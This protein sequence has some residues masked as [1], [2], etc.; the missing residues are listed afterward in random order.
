MLDG[1][2]EAIEN[3]MREF[4]TGMV[5][6][7]L[8]TMY[9]DINEKTGQI[10]TEVGKTPQAWNGSIFGMIRDLSDSVMMPIAGMI[11]TFV[12]CYE[13]VSMLTEKNTMHEIDTWM[14]FSSIS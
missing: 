10:A 14:I 9:A 8:A 1:V 11:I 4:L 12:L 13:L 3:W 6:S 2:L 7:N 5:T